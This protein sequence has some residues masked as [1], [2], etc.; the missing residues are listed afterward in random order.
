M[1]TATITLGTQ[2]I[3]YNLETLVI[4]NGVDYSTSKSECIAE[5][6]F[7]NDTDVFQFGSNEQFDGISFTSGDNYLVDYNAAV[8]AYIQDDGYEIA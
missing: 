4:I 3:T 7:T 2:V 8:N 5:T 6:H 1:T